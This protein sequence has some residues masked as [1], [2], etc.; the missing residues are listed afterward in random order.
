MGDA[1]EELVMAWLE[2]ARSDL[3]SARKL[4]AGPEQFPDTALYHCQQASEKALK[5][6]LVQHD[7][8]FEKTHNLQALVGMCAKI[9]GQFLRLLDSAKA[10]NPY[11]TAYRYPYEAALEP[12]SDE[13]RQGLRMAE[14]ICSAVESCLPKE[15]Q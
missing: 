9:N 11:A 7:V 6:F 2:R 3:G 8:E 10:L 15:S 14:G 12:T 4:L 1:R 5:A 13:A